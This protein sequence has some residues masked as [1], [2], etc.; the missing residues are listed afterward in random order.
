MDYAI[1]ETEWG[2]GVDLISMSCAYYL[3]F[4]DLIM[5]T[6]TNS[7]QTSPHSESFCNLVYVYVCKICE[8]KF[9][10]C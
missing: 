4:S 10:S 7:H 2:S 6:T 3:L 8:E 1:L 5:K 9:G